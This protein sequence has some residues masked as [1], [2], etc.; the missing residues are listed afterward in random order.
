M[1]AT[2]T[3][4]DNK[5][6]GGDTAASH[7]PSTVEVIVAA[8]HA[9]VRL[10]AFLAGQFPEHS[11]VRLQAAI[12][13]GGALVDGRKTVRASERLQPGQRVAI[14]LP[15]V[16]RAGPAPED[17][18]LDVLYEDEHLAAVNKPPG[19]VVHPAKGHWSGT[20]AGAIQHRFGSVSAAG[21]PTRPGIVHR[22]DRDTSGVIVVARND[23]AHMRLAAQFESRGVEKEYFA[24]VAGQP[25][26]DRDLID[27]P[28]GAHPY[29]R[30]K[31]AIRADHPTVREA[32]TF[33]EVIERFDGLAAIRVLPKT[34]RTHQ[35]RVH[36]ASIGCPILC[37]R[38]YG[39]RAKL[40]R[41]ELARRYEDTTT[42]LERQALHA[43]RIAL[44]HPATNVRIEFTAPLAADLVAALEAIHQ[45]RG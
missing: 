45:Y 7:V 27:R 35:I 21:G 19:M 13:D 33:Y 2:G 14:R 43:R 30:E 36:L 44:D 37:D 32:Q 28:I 40:T 18:P 15:D 31:M 3:D 25:R 16:P 10:D 39:G 5:N 42:V 23:Q 22:L 34:G 11:R 29:Q 9:N 26:L 1:N 41:G 12:S 8:E 20:L 38:L 24:I 6:D 4:Y 17:I